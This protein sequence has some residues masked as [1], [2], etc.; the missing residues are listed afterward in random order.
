MKIDTPSR[1]GFGRIFTILDPKTTI[2]D[3][4]NA[5]FGEIFENGHPQPGRIWPD[6]GPK[7]PKGP[8]GAPW[9]PMGAQ[10]AQG[11]QGALGAL[12][13]GAR[14]GSLHWSYCP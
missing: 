11:A 13:G 12:L 4:K 10:G 8:Q 1:G 5:N 7:G 9:G 2:L 6:L 14:E 3:P